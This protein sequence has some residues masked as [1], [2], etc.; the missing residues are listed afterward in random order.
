MSE[1]QIDQA[2]N[3]ILALEHICWDHFSPTYYDFNKYDE[4]GNENGHALMASSI[5]LRRAPA[6]AFTQ[7]KEVQTRIRADPY[8]HHHH[9]HYHHHHAASQQQQHVSSCYSSPCPP[10]CS[11]SSTT[12]IANSTTTTTIPTIPTTP[13]NPALQHAPHH[14]QQQSQ[15]QPQ[16]PIMPSSPSDLVSWP[17]TGLTLEALWGLAATLNPPD[18]ELAPVQAWFEMVRLLGVDAALDAGLMARVRAELA[19]VVKC[20][21]F[22]A[23][24]ERDAFDSVLARVVGG[25]G[26]GGGGGEG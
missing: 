18:R 12:T 2:I 17:T 4:D 1:A 19:G 3:F 13:I 22:G 9:H 7:I 23:V 24:I 10:S 26:G 8:H 6:E 21:H 20:L 11:S 15:P 14:H 25:G 16:P 5:A